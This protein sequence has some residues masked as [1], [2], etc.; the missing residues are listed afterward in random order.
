MNATFALGRRLAVG[1]QGGSSSRRSNSSAAAADYSGYLTAMR[2]MGTDLE[3]LMI[4]EA[5]RQSL[6]D[7]HDRQAREAAASAASASTSASGAS[8][9]AAAAATALNSNTTQGV[10]QGSR[11]RSE[12]G[13]SASLTSTTDDGPESEPDSDQDAPELLHNRAIR[14]A[15]VPI[16]APNSI[17]TGMP[18]HR[19]REGPTHSPEAV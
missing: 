2:N 13:D 6:Q 18:K 1:R 5:M 15:A 14:F 4:M 16:P 17:E 11:A 8:T 9:S 12:G 7:E 10:S 3:E 19:V